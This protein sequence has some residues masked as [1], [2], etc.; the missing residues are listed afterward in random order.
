MTLFFKHL[1]NVPNTLSLIRVASAPLLAVFWLGFGWLGWGLALGTVLGLTDLFDG[2]LARK[3][4]QQT[5]LGAVIDQLG[6]LV[7][8]STCLVI[9]VLVGGMW[10][11]WLIIYLFREFVVQI[12]RNYVVGHGGTLPSSTAGKAKSNYLQWAFFIYFL[13]VILLQ[14]GK[15]PLEWSMVGVSPGQLLIFVSMG[16]IIT[17]LLMGL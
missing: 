8:E 7:F 4:N 17:G 11:G 14:P 5:E 13:G 10:S 2:I 9:A 15:L 6:D 3:L 1:F 16:F 12:C